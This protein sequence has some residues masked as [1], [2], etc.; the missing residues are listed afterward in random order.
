[1][2]IIAI[3]NHIGAS[4]SSGGAETAFV[5]TVQTDNAGTSAA[6]QFT[7]PITSATPY[8]IQTSDGQ[9]IT[10]ATGATTLTF[11]SA[12]EYEIKIS[13]S[14]SGFTFN[15]GGDRLKLKNISNWG[16]FTNDVQQAFRACSNMT[17][18]AVD[19]PLN[20]PTTMMRTFYDCP[21]FNG[22][23]GNWDVSQVSSFQQTFYNSGGFDQPL[24]DW[25]VS[26][27]STFFSIFENTSF[28]QPLDNWILNT[29][30]SINC[31]GMFSGTDF[32][33]PSIN[34]WNTSSVFNMSWMFANCPF[35]QDISGWDVSSVT[36][37]FNMFDRAASFNQPIGSWN[38]SNVANFN[39]MFSRASSF[40]QPIGSWNTGSAS[41]LNSTFDRASS[42]NQPIDS[43]DVSGVVDMRSVFSSATAFN[44]PLNNWDTSGCTT[45]ISMFN[46]AQSF[47]QDLNNWNVLK[48]S[49]GGFGSMFQ[50]CSSFNGSLAGWTFPQAT[51]LDR[52]FNF[53]IA[54]NNNSIATW[55]VSNI[56][57]LSYTFRSC[58][59]F[60][61]DIS[62]WNTS[63]VDDMIELFQNCSSFNQPIG[64]WDVSKVTRF[65]YFLFNA[66]SFNQPLNN[67]DVSS[68]TTFSTMFYGASSFNQDIGDW[69]MSSTASGS[70]F[71][72]MFRSA[73]AYNNGGQ[74][75]NWITSPGVTDM[76]VMFYSC[77]N[78]KQSL[79]SINITTLSSKIDFN[80]LVV[81]PTES[82]NATLVGWNSQL[83]AAYP[84]GAG[85]S[86]NLGWNFNG[87]TYTADSAAEAARTNLI[88]TFGWTIVDGGAVAEAFDFTV[89][90]AVASGGH[91]LNTQY[92][93]PLSAT[94]SINAT[95]NWGDGNSDTITAYTDPAALHTYA[96]PGIYNISI[97]GSISNFNI[98]GGAA[99][100]TFDDR[101]KLSSIE[102]WGQF[103]I[104]ASNSFNAAINF[105]STPLDAPKI[106]TTSLANTFYLC[107][108][109]NGYVNSWDMVGVTSL[110]GFFNSA[111][112]FNQ[113]VSSWQTN[114]VTSLVSSFRS[115]IAF[116][117]PLNSWN[118][119]SVVS[120][121]SLFNNADSFNQPLNN[122]D[123]TNV[124]NCQT[125]FQGAAVFNQDISGW[126]TSGW[127]FPQSIFDGAPAFNQPIGS[128]N[129]A[130]WSG[131]R[132][133]FNNCPGFDQDISSWPPTKS[134]N[135]QFLGGTS[136]LS[137]LNYG[138]LLD[139]WS[140][141]VVLS[142][143]T[144]D[145][146]GSTYYFDGKGEAGKNSLVSTYSLIFLDGGAT[147]VLDNVPTPSVAYS[148]R[149]LKTG[150]TNVVRVR[151]DSDNAEQDFT[152]SQVTDGTLTTFVGAG[153]G[154]VHTLYDQ[155]GNGNNAVSTNP[156]TQPLVVVSGVLVTENGKPM[157]DYTEVTANNLTITTPIAYTN[158]AY[159]FF[160]NGTKVS[161]IDA[162]FL[163]GVGGSFELRFGT[164][165][166]VT[167]LRA[168]QRNLGG[169]N[170]PA[171]TGH[172]AVSCR[173]NQ[174]RPVFVAN[175][176]SGSGTAAG[177]FTQPITQ[178]GS[179][180]MGGESFKGKMG[181]FILYDTDQWSNQT[182]IQ[183]AIN[184][185][186]LIY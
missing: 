80:H 182:I 183:D 163:G 4:R 21:S 98:V 155:S 100:Q 2:N 72:E 3:S 78:F 47:N 170:I 172:Y 180:S 45:M 49:G 148:L 86:I 65:N 25:D 57:K 5:F 168:G 82:Y 143:R 140:Q 136:A 71:K 153:N 184:D 102:K 127:A 77:L 31:F 8:D 92:Q 16:V 117:W 133:V 39:Y 7:I 132:Q 70:G 116:N 59:N 33:N 15:I 94:G 95:V 58:T 124:V 104:V 106:S 32:N 165:S 87:S 142:G 146:G 145:M 101:R 161:S 141:G 13:E 167:A 36:D 147:Y 26:N 121:D 137:P 17:C 76:S 35:N 89:N 81:L 61:V 50:S 144:W 139:V 186:Y 29:S 123:T 41:S 52:M 151:R 54:F 175:T 111:T 68:C 115:A 34:N 179:V 126:N 60:D 119:D 53:A 83:E 156:L 66:S 85:Y 113:P 103:E 74:P 118:V 107:G 173:V 23:V 30:I 88:N 122:W 152:A 20:P 48:V 97:D 112:V 96:A 134:N 10:G 120:I 1:M 28:S 128:W 43:W 131:Y 27:G 149:Q 69:D 160:G 181:D 56:T 51:T 129:P 67:W 110:E 90:T 62:G 38:V 24:N 84:G 44:Q 108:T 64:N 154:Y 174:T 159:T 185:Y 176:T 40:N 93:L 171:N 164:G 130:G 166:S 37:M 177:S 135:A 19:A 73:T 42:F 125:V 12:G 109:F 157:L 11:P 150:V 105:T 22:A 91:S 158:S 162:A 46:N 18:S 79:H 114:T 6:D 63:N 99:A 138:K 9:S 55:D 14:C 178:V 75:I 169:M